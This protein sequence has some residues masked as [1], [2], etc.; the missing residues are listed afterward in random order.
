MKRKI[1]LAVVCI[2]L[3]A[4]VILPSGCAPQEQLV[5]ELTLGSPSPMEDN[6]NKVILTSWGEW[7]ERESEGRI[8]L[9]IL[10]SEQ[11]AKADALY[12]AARD[13]VVDMAECLM[14]AMPGRFPL[15]EITSLPLIFG[16]PSARQASLT[17]MALYEEYP[18]LQAEFEGVKVICFHY[19]GPTHIN[20]TK[21]PIHTLEDCKGLLEIEFSGAGVKVG[22]ALGMSPQMMNP[23]EMADALSKGVVD[24]ICTNWVAMY[25]FGFQNICN[26]STELG[27]TQAGF[28][29]V[30]NLDT[31]NKLPSDLQELFEG[32][33]AWRLASL[34]GHQ[35]DIDDAACKDLLNEAYEARG[36]PEV[37]VLPDA[38][39]ASWLEKIMPLRD[40]W[41]SSMEA[42]GVPAEKIL[43][44]CISFAEQYKYTGFSQE[45][46]DIL[47][48]WGAFG[49]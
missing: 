35:F 41:V 17:H 14:P 42:A 9:T 20:T 29:L 26:Y 38:E 3:V 33:N 7:L 13:G 49:H 23:G 32:D 11:A 18:E 48:E 40:E 36:L 1:F 46:E 21:E 15:N 28:V 22:Q 44:D 47:H 6:M 4:A 37:Y 25:A 27:I 12:D 2:V 43:E 8:T 30:M 45:D 5:F 16:W 34:F 24:G 31:W 10:P 39:R 19:G